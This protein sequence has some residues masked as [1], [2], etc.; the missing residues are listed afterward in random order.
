[1]RRTV[2]VGGNGRDRR[3]H[4]GRFGGD[5]TIIQRRPIG[6]FSWFPLTTTT[7][8]MLRLMGG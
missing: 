5:F 7:D 8:A 4:D 6:L 2:P 1:M 3:S